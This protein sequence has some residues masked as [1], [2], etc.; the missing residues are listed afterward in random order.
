MRV[1]DRT[2]SV[3]GALWLPAD[4]SREAPLIVGLDFLGPFGI[5]SGSRFPRDPNAVVH[6]P[7]RFGITDGSLQD[8][9]RG[10]AAPSWPMEMLCAAGYAVL[11]SCYGSWVPDHPDRW[12]T[13]GVGPLT[14]APVAGSKAI[15]LWAWSM[16]RLVDAARSFPEIDGRRIALAGHSRLGKAALWAAANDARISAVLANNSGCG[17]AAPARHPV[18]ETLVEMQ[19]AFPHWIRADAG[20]KEPDQL[21]FDQH[22]LLA[23]I[24]PRA[25]LL[26]EAEDDIWADPL[27]S[28]RALAAA[29]AST[30]PSK[31]PWPSVE[32]AWTRG[33]RIARGPF[34]WHLRPGGHALT[35]EDWRQFVAFLVS[36]YM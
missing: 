35:K 17:G 16:M 33:A 11:V 29:S 31:A 32:T 28:Y 2:F 1:A 14:G 10:A 7:P 6:A 24:A 3:D 4:R 13:H 5:L 26:T 15:S 20:H 19:A 36:T 21:P 34:A 12:R 27:G 23:A 8:A 18:G 9:L 22:A 25:V 30:A